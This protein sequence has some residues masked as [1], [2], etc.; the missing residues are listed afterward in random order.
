MRRQWSNIENT[1][2]LSFFHSLSADINYIYLSQMAIK[3]KPNF[4]GSDVVGWMWTKRHLPPWG[5]FL[6]QMMIKWTP[7]WLYII[8]RFYSS[9]KFSLSSCLCHLHSIRHFQS[10][11]KAITVTAF[12]WVNLEFLMNFTY[13][14][15]I[16]RVVF[17]V[18]KI[19][20]M[21]FSFCDLVVGR[22]FVH[23]SE[24]LPQKRV[25]RRHFIFSLLLLSWLRFL[26]SFIIFFLSCS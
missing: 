24:K 8:L 15:C 1:D 6:P 9:F 17:D 10:K 18:S 20:S 11:L 25:W 12:N 3:S 26:F 13:R 2:V 5:F 21:Q 7:E 16:L 19:F 23:R 22:L 4:L 14:K